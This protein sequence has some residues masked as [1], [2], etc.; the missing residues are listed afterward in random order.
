MA[1]VP[2]TIRQTQVLGQVETISGTAETLTSVDGGVRVFTSPEVSLDFPLE[3]L[4]YARNTMTALGKLVTTKAMGI[5]FRSPVN[6]PD[7][8]TSEDLEQD[9]YLQACGH[10]IEDLYGIGI[11]AIGSGPFTRGETVTDESAATGRV[12]RSTATG[13]SWLYYD[14]ISGTLSTGETLTGSSSGATATSSSGGTAHGYIGK[15]VSNDQKTITM[16]KEEDGFQWTIAGAMSNFNLSA[17]N[18][19]PAYFDFAF[20]GPY[21]SHGA[22]AMTTGIDYETEKPPKFQGAGLTI[23]SVASTSLVVKSV[24]FDQNSAP[25]KRE[26]AN[27]ATTGIISMYKASRGDGPKLTI[28]LEMP[29]AATLDIL[30]NLIAE[31]TAAI[32]F[33]VG[34]TKGKAFMFFAD[35]AQVESISY[36]DTDGIR[37]IDVVYVCVGSATSGDDEYEMIWY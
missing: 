11:G 10:S 23:S 35:Y 30:Q 28:S 1:E 17:E 16:R 29:P 2:Y 5:A 32:K 12:L 9:A 36:T 33:N 19:K 3:D 34:T 27:T 15:P 24:A 18:S 8:I 21:V 20:A 7:T 26:D 31:T 25:V 4:P 22:Q 6:T 14:P 13:E 37:T